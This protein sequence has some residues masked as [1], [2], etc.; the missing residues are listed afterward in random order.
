M[1]RVVVVPDEAGARVA[2]EVPGAQVLSLP[3]IEAVEQLVE[4]LTPPVRVV[5]SAVAEQARRNAAAR[6]E[7]LAENEALDAEGVAELAGS[8]AANRRATA[9]R[10]QGEQ[11]C[12]GV[13]HGGR[14]L[15]PAFQFDPAT[16]R[17][18]PAVAEVLTALRSIGLRGWSLALWWTTPHDALGWQRPIDVLGKAPQD[19]IEAA[20]LDARTRG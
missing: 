1:L 12:F 17:P 2:E 11:R 9:S 14:L 13:E 19:V 15:F 20:R 5:S 16:R 4:T 7:F 18:V 3:Q 6:A 10:W 8:R